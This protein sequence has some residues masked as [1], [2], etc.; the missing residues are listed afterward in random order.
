MKL[1]SKTKVLIFSSSRG[2]TL[3][4]LSLSQ[5]KT[6]ANFPQEMD[7]LLKNLGVV[8]HY[9]CFVSLI[10]LFLQNRNKRNIFLLLHFFFCSIKTCV[11]KHAFWKQFFFKITLPNIFLLYIFIKKKAEKQGQKILLN[12]PLVNLKRIISYIQKNQSNQHNLKLAQENAP[13]QF[14]ICQPILLKGEGL[15]VTLSNSS[16]I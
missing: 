13:N 10:K 16:R 3:F 8:L 2:R 4:P 11:L 9:F 12:S 1:R 6:S 15:V 14:L 7:N 5:L